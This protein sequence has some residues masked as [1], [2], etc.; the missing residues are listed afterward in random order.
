MDTKLL[1]DKLQQEKA[2]E[3]LWT[4]SVLSGPG[5]TQTAQYV[6]TKKTM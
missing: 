6:V 5:T 3:F 4:S 2:F 1:E